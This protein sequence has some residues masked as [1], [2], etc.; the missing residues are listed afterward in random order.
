MKLTLGFTPCPNDTFIFYGLVH[1]MVPFGCDLDIRLMDVQSLNIEATRGTFAMSKLSCFAYAGV[2]RDYAILR[3]GAALGRGCGPLL[4]AREGK[5]FDPGVRIAIPG[6]LTTAHLLLRIFLGGEAKSVPM[7]FD[8][9]MPAMQKGEIDYGV[10]IHEGRFTYHNYG[11]T[12]IEDLG[13]FWERRFGLPIP[14]GLIAARRDIGREIA[15]EFEQ[16]L[17]QSVTFARENRERV[18]RYVRQHAQELDEEV[19][20]RHIDLYVNDDTRWLSEK[21]KDAVRLLLTKAMESRL[22]APFPLELCFVG[23]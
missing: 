13:E 8:H 20:S 22:V 23:D 4:L 1:K 17:A 3:S 9:I 15:R 7:R 18:L 14:L 5:K 12:L 21:G 6:E 16:K 10:V 19:M 11:L 2:A